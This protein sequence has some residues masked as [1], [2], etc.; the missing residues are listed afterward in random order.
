MTDLADQYLEISPNLLQAFPKT[1]AA[2][3][4][5]AFDEKTSRIKRISEKGARFDKEL[6]ALVPALAENG[7]LYLSR[8]DY[9]EYSKLLSDHI[10]VLLTEDTLNER[11]V[12]EILFQGLSNRLS[13][14]F[15]QPVEAQLAPLQA[16]IIVLCEYIWAEPKRVYAFYHLF[17]SYKHSLV[18]HSVTS[19][20]LSLALFK[21]LLGGKIQDPKVMNGLALGVLLHDIGMLS[22]PEYVVNHPRQLIQQ[23]RLRM[24]EHTDLGEKALARLGI[25]AKEV[26]ACVYEHHERIDGSGYPRRLKGEQ[27]HL[28]AQICAV[29]DAFCA[30]TCERSYAPAKDFIKA[31]TELIRNKKHYNKAILQALAMYLTRLRKEHKI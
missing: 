3:R 15:E 7:L 28:F 9:K 4:L 22:V 11:D 2:V 26:K 10:G 12:S 21:L 19:T 27:I 5:Y 30:M 29:A 16:D 23:E 25:H 13:A 8:D 14:F 18:A 24:Q 31:A 6:K 1:R 17:G 20:L